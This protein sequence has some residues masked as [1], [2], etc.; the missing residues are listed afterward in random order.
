MR[1]LFLLAVSF[2]YGYTPH[3]SLCPNP[4]KVT[5]IGTGYVGLI[6]GVGLAEFG[7]TVVCADIDQSKIALLQKGIIPIYEPGL[8]EVVDKNVEAGRLQFTEEVD[9]AILMSDLIFIAVG[10]PMGQEGKADLSIVEAVAKQIGENI[11]RHKIVCVKSTV[12]I[13]SARKI[14]EWIGNGDF[15]YVF[16]PEFLREGVALFDFFEPDRVVLGVESENAKKIMKEIYQPLEDRGVP[17][18]FTNFET[19][20]AIK[21]ASNTFLAVKISFINEFAHLCEEVGADVLD[22]AKGMGLDNR[23]GS[24]F[25]SPG[26]G[27]GGSCIPKD[28]AAL[29]Y[30][31][32]EAGVDLKV[33]QAAVTANTLQKMRVVEKVQGLLG[34]MHGKTIGILGLSFKG[35]TDDVRESP[36][37]VIIQSLLE[38]GAIVKAYDPQGMPNMRQ[39]FPEIEYV[40]NAYSAAVKA[41]ALIVLTDWEEFRSLD[42]FKIKS[43]MHQPNIVDARNMFDA[44]ALK[45]L[46][47]KV[48]NI[49]RPN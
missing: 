19:A 20:E 25:L 10:T 31:A 34:S 4:Q 5:V 9:E 1:F 36:A 14:C 8:K 45:E 26:P 42:L 29:L 17:F 3:C 33:V 27:F 2:V 43:A 48:A 40:D 30:R 28:A 32:K 41:D 7:H 12:P 21:Y 11:N 23:I 39:I 16:N 22:V 37:L 44:K 13:G 49:G 35:N 24:A 47:I 46:G 15:E 38:Q 18:L 6:L